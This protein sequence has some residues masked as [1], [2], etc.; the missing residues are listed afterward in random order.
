LPDQKPKTENGKR[1]TED[2]SAMLHHFGHELRRH[3]PLL[4]A[5][6][7]LLGLHLFL[8][9]SRF[10]EE[11]SAP[12][13]NG[14]GLIAIFVTAAVFLPFL[15]VPLIVQ[16]DAPLD[17]NAFWA[18]RPLRGTSLFGGKLLLVALFFVLLPLGVEMA[19]LALRGGGSRVW[20]AVPEFLFVRGAITCVAFAAATL[21]RRLD[22]AVAILGCLVL[23]AVGCL[24]AFVSLGG[25]D[26]MRFPRFL[27]PSRILL[28][29]VLA[30]VGGL[31]A[32]WVLY[33]DRRVGWGAAITTVTVALATLAM[34]AWHRAGS[35]SRSRANF[36]SARGAAGRSAAR[37]SRSPRQGRMA[38][39]SAFRSERANCGRSTIANAR[40]WRRG[41]VVRG[42]SSWCIPP[43]A[44]RSGLN[45]TTR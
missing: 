29:G 11:Q 17:E 4:L 41:T 5:W 8:S 22:H 39:A 45:P 14:K 10:V 38:R 18:T 2:I 19:I 21:A 16:A 26:A 27:L 40:P 9:G 33:R 24:L 7:V 6:C 3:A 44:R 34:I 20:L 36:R 31:L 15:L 37:R 43:G 1:N 25:A 13:A 42:R 12:G 35:P 28:F 30:A 23:L 32:A